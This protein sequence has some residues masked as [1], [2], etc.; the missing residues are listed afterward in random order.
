MSDLSRREFLRKG[1]IGVAAG[2]VAAELAT[3]AGVAKA[4]TRHSEEAASS[5]TDEAASEPVVA[6]VKQGS[7]GEVR[8]MVGSREIVH[9]D[10]ELARRILRAA[11]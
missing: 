3:N 2:V 10:A 8:V 5:S 6:Y 9:R 7:R 11:R 1:S 4:V